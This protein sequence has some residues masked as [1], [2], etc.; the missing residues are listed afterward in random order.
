[1][2]ISIRTKLTLWYTL[3]LVVT[4]FVYVISTNA[5]SQRQYRRDPSDVFQQ[6]SEERSPVFVGTNHPFSASGLSPDE[7]RE[8]IDQIRKE[9]LRTVRIASFSIFAILALLSFAGGYA[10]SG[11]MLRPLQKVNDATKKLD[12]NNLH[13]S[14]EGVNSKD[15]IGEL[16]ANF[17][18]MTDRLHHSFD[19][20]K[21]FVENASHELK[22]PLTISQTNLEAVLQDADM[23]KPEFQENVRNAVHSIGF[24]NDLIED[25]LLLSITKEQISKEEL[26]LKELI[27]DALTQ[28]RPLADVAH[29]KI[30]FSAQIQDASDT[31]SGNK[32]L[33]QR[34]LMNCVENAIRYANTHI[35][36][37]LTKKEND[38]ELRI[39]D[40]GPGIPE[41]EQRNVWER[42]YRIDSA[43]S[44]KDGGTGLGMAITKA[45][46]EL[47]DG[48]VEIDSSPS[49]GTTIILG[50]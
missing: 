7:I 27:D 33:L 30:E 18:D 35:R 29:K 43:R 38:I 16:I 6:I 9:D 11:R 45:I 3:I 48:T 39:H 26:S 1:M 20:Q 41:Y 23:S 46:I 44:R 4:L 49:T 47:H 5:I 21:Q 13:I 40:D 2:K 50:L 15:E 31:Y 8:Y 10:I 28:L 24:M 19:L 25:L 12:A 36:I 37:E 17:N 22:T 32:T 42:F 34:A 14:I